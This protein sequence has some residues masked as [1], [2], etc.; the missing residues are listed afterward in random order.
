MICPSCGTENRPGARFCAGCGAA[1]PLREEPPHQPL[2]PQL[3]VPAPEHTSGTPGGSSADVAQVANKIGLFG[4]HGLIT[5]GALIALFAFMLPW[6]SCSGVR[7]SGLDIVTQSSQ[8]SGD[9]SGTGLV[10]VP[11]AA[12]ALLVLGLAGLAVNLW[13]KSLP[14]N[15]ARLVPFLPL[16]AALP[17]LCGCCPSCAFFLNV[18]NA[19]SGPDNLG[20]G[21][22]IQ[23][24]YGFWLTLVGLGM[25]LVGMI[26]AAVAGLLAQRRS[27]PP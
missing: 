5:V 6:A 7:L 8:Y 19:R 20:L 25:A 24:E 17:G 26:A 3:A 9:A 11:L 18:Q 13:G 16:L 4:G 1:L 14:V 10:L 12:L 23:I 27:A 21:M 22:L 15:L 2:G